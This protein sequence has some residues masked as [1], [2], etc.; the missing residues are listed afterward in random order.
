M[1]RI[2]QF[3][4]VSLLFFAVPSSFLAQTV[5][6]N[7]V[8]GEV[9]FQLKTGV[10]LKN[11][12]VNGTVDLNEIAAVRRLKDRYRIT[13]VRRPF[14]QA[15]DDKLQRTYLVHF[16]RKGDVDS[17][18]RALQKDPDVVYAEKAPLFHI[19][20]TPND[21]EYNAATSK[22]W[23]LTTIQAEQAWDIQKGNPN[24]VIAVVD[25]GVYV[26]HPDLKS[27]IVS[28]TD[29][30]NGDS[31]PT[32]P[33]QTEDWSH[34]THVSGL[35]GAATDNGVGIASIG[36]NVS[37]MAVK[38]AYDSSD[39]R[40]M[41]FGYQG[42]VWAADHHA[43]IINMSW[44][45]PG[46]YQTGQ[47]VVNYAY[48]K[49]C[50][51]VAAAGNDGNDSPSYPADYD[52]VIAVAA[53][54]QDDTKA[55]FSQYGDAVDVCAPGGHNVFGNA[56]IYSSVY[57]PKESYGFMQGTSMASPI[58]AGLAGIM[59]SE[60]TLLTPEKLEAIMKA[61]CDNIDAKNPDFVGLLGAGRINALAALRAVSDSMAL[62]TVVA[63]FKAS[64]VSVPEGGAVSFTDLSTGSPTSW[65]WSF[66]GG[67]PASST[68][69]N[70]AN[71]KYTKPGAY[72]VKLTVSNGS[73]SNTETKTR[74]ILVYPLVSGAWLP[75]AT[76]FSQQSVGINYIYIVNPDVVWAN[77]YD[78]SGK[79]NNLLQFT[80]TVN[81]GEKWIPGKYNG[82]PSAYK[83]SCIAAVD[84]S[85]AWV[86]VY[87]TD[88]NVGYGG[89]Y[90]T[91]D[92]GKTWNHQSTA[93][94]NNKNSFP[95][96]VYFWNADVGLCFGDPVNNYFEIYTTSDGGQNWVPVPTANIPPALLSG[97]YG[98]TNLYAVSDSVF[99]FGTN[100]GRIFKS[101]DRGHHWSVSST[102]LSDLSTLGFHNDSLG[103]AT[104]TSYSQTGTITG[105]QMVKSTDG[106][107]TWTSVN[108]TGTYYKS[109]MAVVP[110]A[111]GMLVSTGISQK[112]SENGSA[113]SMDEGNTWKQ[114]DDSI[115]YTSVK[116]YNSA[117]G[118]AGGFNESSTLRGIW[119]WLGIPT[120]VKETGIGKDALKVFPNPSSGILHLYVPEAKK[121]FD[122]SIFDMGGKRVRHFRVR[123]VNSSH[124]FTLNLRDLKR[125]LYVILLEGD[126]MLLKKKF[127]VR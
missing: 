114:L 5:D 37:L 2:T 121:N 116:F 6:P 124:T 106:G 9:Y 10:F 41:Y 120:A 60:D 25:N 107:K 77:A 14:Y 80:K 119:K 32:P 85:K 100:K 125:G 104:Y 97:E 47:N 99:W 64:T 46:Y 75:Q 59:L 55:S 82:V 67:T 49:G 90:A 38:I 17:L 8:D 111:P 117:V 44:G 48:N 56:G 66:Q 26:N 28:R 112:M 23:H 126:Q 13:K 79:Q 110:Q 20:Y 122:V 35:A 33:K 31:D 29:L 63:N 62:H 51:L 22:R 61:T 88:A 19:F 68:E 123:V 127:F 53:T 93:L 101:T 52:H 108:P 39:G 42:I 24:V 11:Q 78:G 15:N 65:K 96:V 50:V 118:W 57:L 18:V 105:F 21:P 3:I 72:E 102:G 43:N 30:A 109:D 91:S 16:K 7:A 70:P 69:Q 86:A 74:F 89:I 40:S 12:G 92:G 95:D 71:I 4:L 58:V 115:Q 73:T 87:S 54:N 113:Y 94:F 45:G 34:G 27:K 83:V 81:G 103:M 98:Y 76:G 36:F 1:K 84:S